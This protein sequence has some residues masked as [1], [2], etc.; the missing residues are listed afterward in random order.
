MK[1]FINIGYI[2]SL[3]LTVCAG[4]QAQLRVESEV[5]ELGQLSWYQNR[6]LELKITNSGSK[7]I[8]IVGVRTSGSQL[9]AVSWPETLAAGG[10]GKVSFIVDASLL[11][12]FDRVVL[13]DCEDT[14][15]PIT[16]HVKGQVVA[17]L[18]TNYNGDYPYQVDNVL[19]STDNIEFDDASVGDFPEQVIEVKNAGNAVYKP[20][21]MHL[22]PYLSQ[23]AVP[24]ELLPGRA[25]KLIVTLNTE[26]VEGFGLKQTTVY[27]SRFPGD[28]VGKDN[29]VAVSSVV[30][31]QVDTSSVIQS[32]LRPVL[33]MD[34]TELSFPALAPGKKA[35]GVI[36]LRN[37][38]KS[39]LEITS[40]QVFHPAVS[41]NLSKMKIAPGQT[42]KLKLTVQQKYLGLSRSR[43]RVLMTTDDPA[44]PKVF[45][46]V[47]QTANQQ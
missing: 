22:P 13:I 26:K 6:T 23:R 19:L 36:L 34:A 39:T 1:K 8:K 46:D 40:L 17:D 43:L 14:G 2:A 37:D 33:W 45:I 5:M 11:G 32:A 7:A 21:L 44:H 28:R 20:E 47:K 15:A 38:G 25:G 16:V 27:V 30:L 42:E 29:E 12:R 9:K 35:K 24:E 18:S 31:P 10:G 41:V 4:L 3:L